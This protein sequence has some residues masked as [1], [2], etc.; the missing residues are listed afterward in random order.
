MS[1][2]KGLWVLLAAAVLGVGVPGT[3]AGAADVPP[4]VEQVFD[5]NKGQLYSVYQRALRDDPRLGGKVNFQITIDAAGAVADCRI[6]SSDLRT[7][8]VE[9]KMCERIRLWM[10]EPQT[11]ARTVSKTVQFFSRVDLPAN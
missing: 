8:S 5:H 4:D 10:F 2:R 11:A 6:V 9:K 1:M 3:R 7:P